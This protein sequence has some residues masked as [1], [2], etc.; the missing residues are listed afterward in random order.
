MLEKSGTVL[1]VNILLIYYSEFVCLETL[2][3][4]TLGIIEENTE[5]HV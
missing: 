4:T 2:D 3:N 5:D 1:V